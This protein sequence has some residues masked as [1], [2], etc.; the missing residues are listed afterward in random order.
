MRNLLSRTCAAACMRKPSSANRRVL[1][2][3]LYTLLTMLENVWPIVAD[4][5]RRHLGVTRRAQTHTS[6]GICCSVAT[7]APTFQG[8]GKFS[9]MSHA[10]V[11]WSQ[12]VYITVRPS[13]PGESTP[14]FEH[15]IDRRA[16]QMRTDKNT[17]TFLPTR[18][19]RGF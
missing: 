6:A 17:L 16:H 19:I 15:T 2:L 4:A 3:A 18:H 9:L 1:V 12:L 7:A 8:Y 13:L 11:G 10:G 5:A 14:F